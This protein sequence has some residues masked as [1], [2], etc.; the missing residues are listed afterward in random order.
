MGI[1]GKLFGGGNTTTLGSVNG[2][3]IEYDEFNAK[4]KEMEQQYPNSGADQRNQIMQSVWD[5]M[6]A[7][8][9]V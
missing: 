7:E 1:L 3:K 8:K 6:V 4:V 5:Q 9:I 2:D